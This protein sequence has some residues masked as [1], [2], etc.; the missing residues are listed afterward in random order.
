MENET[1]P[2][3][4]FYEDKAA[5]L[6]RLGLQTHDDAVKRQLMTLALDFE[7][8]AERA[9]RLGRASVD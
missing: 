4:E 6:R 9:R 2:S 5:E 1:L 7:K 3:T 8:L